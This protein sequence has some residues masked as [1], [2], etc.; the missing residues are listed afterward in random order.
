MENTQLNNTETINNFSSLYTVGNKIDQS[1]EANKT[2]IINTTV[3]LLPTPIEQFLQHNYGQY[4][5]DQILVH[6][7][8]PEVLKYEIGVASVYEYTVH[9]NAKGEFDK[10]DLI[11]S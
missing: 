2:K 6:K 8:G 1:E 9:F 5:I 3:N 11:E 4:S 7:E 10:L